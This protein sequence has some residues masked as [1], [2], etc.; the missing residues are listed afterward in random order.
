[1]TTYSE[2]QASQ[3]LIK[4]GRSMFNRGLTGGASANVSIR[5]DS[6]FVISPTNSCIGFLDEHELSVLDADGRHVRGEKPSKEFAL[7]KAFYDQRPQDN[8]VIHLHST[9][10]T[11]LSCLDLPDDELFPPLTP[12]LY[13]RLGAVACV[14]YYAPGDKALAQ[15]VF[16]KTALTAG[17]L[18]RNHGPIVSGKNITSAMYAIEEL[19][20]SA[21]LTL[22]L[23]QQNT[24]P[25]PAGSVDSLLHQYGHAV[26]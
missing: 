26:A 6:G 23:K 12:Y 14:D 3:A 21:K 18:M 13:I 16:E 17:V 24:R 5:T 22:L 20:E 2:N 1:M 10:A 25:M 9:Y 19:E 8:S 4:Y 7:H 15:A 11:A